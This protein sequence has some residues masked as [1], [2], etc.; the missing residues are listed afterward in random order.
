MPNP[1]VSATATSPIT[2]AYSWIAGQEFPASRPLIDVAQAVP[3]YAPAS[4][5]TNH[6]AEVIG[7]A[8]L[9][10]Y[11]PVLGV[12]ELRQALARDISRAYAATV[13][14]SHVAI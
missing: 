10:R 14:D 2:E 5:L 4:S 11:G 13:P 12:P 3:G 1:L 6:L 7:Q 9:A 8:D